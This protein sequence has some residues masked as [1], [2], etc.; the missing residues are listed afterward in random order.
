VIYISQSHNDKDS[1]RR[2]FDTLL[3]RIDH[4]R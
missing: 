1:V 2:L 4:R 3:T